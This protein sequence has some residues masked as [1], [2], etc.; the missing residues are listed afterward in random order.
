MNATIE[1]LDLELFRK[2][3]LPA[4]VDAKEIQKDKRPIEVQLASLVAFR[5]LR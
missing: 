2:T 4:M 3:L 5:N 1:D